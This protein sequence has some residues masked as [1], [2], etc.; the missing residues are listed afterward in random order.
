MS[1]KSDRMDWWPQ[2]FNS[3]ARSSEGL[4]GCAAGVQSTV[5]VMPVQERRQCSLV[6]LRAW[7]QCQALCEGALGVVKMR[8]RPTATAAA[9]ISPGEVDDG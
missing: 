6:T 3:S 1:E 9:T 5:S 2:F 8:V 7:S 4:Q